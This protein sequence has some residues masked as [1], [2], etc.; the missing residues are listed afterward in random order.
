[1]YCFRFCPDCGTRLE[2]PGI[3]TERL[4]AQVCPSCGAEHFRNAKP[5]AGAL[6]ISDGKVLLARRAIEPQKGAWDIPGGFLNAWEHPQDCALRE[7]REETGLT[8]ELHRML[9]VEIDAYGASYYTLNIYYVATPTGGDERPADD[10]DQLRWFG[11]D[12]LP[13]NLA[14][15]HAHRV[16]AA[17]TQSLDGS[18]IA[19]PQNLDVG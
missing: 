18:G 4:I 11:P 10:V 14:F 17:W 7:V 1:V 13:T 15:A 16:L 5:C 9:S 19:R 2:T 8:V 3:P 12:E 6:V